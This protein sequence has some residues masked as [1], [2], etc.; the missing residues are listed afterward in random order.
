[1]RKKTG[2]VFSPLWA[3][4]TVEQ[5]LERW[6]ETPITENLSH[7]IQAIQM[8]PVRLCFL[9]Y[10]RDEETFRPHSGEKSNLCDQCNFAFSGEGNL[11]GHMKMYSEEKQTN[12]IN[13]RKCFLSAVGDDDR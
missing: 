11:R 5:S 3:T 8:Q 2:S 9:L 6:M 1:M 10:K 12:A 4:M 7:P 13:D